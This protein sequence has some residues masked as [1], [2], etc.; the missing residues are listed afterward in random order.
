[1]LGFHLRTCFQSDWNGSKNWRYRRRYFSTGSYS[2]FVWILQ[3][4]QIQFTTV[5]STFKNYEKYSLSANNRRRKDIYT[6]P[7]ADQELLDG[8]GYKNKLD[9]VDQA[10]VANSTFLAKIVEDTEIFD[11]VEERSTEDETGRGKSLHLRSHNSSGDTFH[12]AMSTHVFQRL[13]DLSHTHSDSRRRH[14]HVGHTG[15][16]NNNKTTEFDMDKL[17]GTLKQF[18]RDWSE[19]VVVPSL[20]SAPSWLNPILICRVKMSVKPVTSQW[21]MHYSHISPTYRWTNGICSSR[22]WTGFGLEPL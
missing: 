17:R 11:D 5:V 20:Y 10:I 8:L 4:E 22:L 15:S 21:K 19:E 14:Q 16:T 18:V 6:L 9:A 13:I 2:T 1:V 7:R 12:L 3:P